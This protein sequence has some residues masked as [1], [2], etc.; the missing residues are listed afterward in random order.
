MSFRIIRNDITKIKADAIVNTANPDVAVGDG[1]DKAI[2]NAAGYDRL[3]E[4]RKQIGVLECGDVCITDAFDLDAKYII[5]VSGPIWDDGKSNEESILRECYDKALRLAADHD[6]KSI[7]FPLIST[8]TYGFPKELGIQI[9]VES[10][11]KFLEN[12]EMDIIL[13][14]FERDSVNISGKLVEEVT[15]YIDDKYVDDALAD[16]YIND[17]IPND[18]LSALETQSAKR[19]GLFRGRKAERRA[20]RIRADK[21]RTFGCAPSMNSDMA[22]QEICEDTVQEPGKKKESLDDVLKGIY[23]DSFEKHLQQLI[24]K[25]GL[26]NSEVY[27]AANISKQYFSKL[28]KGQ[29]KPSKEKMLALAVGLRI[30]LDETIDFLKIA[31]YA[32]SP[33]SQTD[34][35]VEYFIERKDYNVIKIDIVLFDYGLDP[36]SKT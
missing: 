33:I 4:Q 32:L 5:H 29:V 13:A 19:F 23:T 8:G 21:P 25:K 11:T 7:A 6:C 12:Y 35:V 1:V 28:L 18:T 16:E 14:V 15:S 30:N 31:G 10:F 27:A 34:A 2:Y 36:L 9:A 22:A 17:G 24:N 26:K 3:L 20:G